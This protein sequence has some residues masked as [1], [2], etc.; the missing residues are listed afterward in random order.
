M[1][2][3]PGLRSRVT[4]NCQARFWIG[5]GAGDRP[6]DHN[7]INAKKYPADVVRGKAKKY[8]EYKDS[9]HTD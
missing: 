4:G 1:T 2:E 9:T 5:G 7:E 8:T 3:A 6:A